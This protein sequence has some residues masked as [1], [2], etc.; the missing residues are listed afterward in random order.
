M[1]HMQ[2]QS[3]IPDSVIYKYVEFRYS[4]CYIFD[5]SFIEYQFGLKWSYY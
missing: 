4:N 2:C 3:V 5:G 1:E